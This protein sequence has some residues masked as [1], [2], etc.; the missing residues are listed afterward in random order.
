MNFDSYT[1]TA[2][3]G[4]IVT[5]L[6]QIAGIVVNAILVKRKAGLGAILSLIGFS[7]LLLVD[8]CGYAYNVFLFQVIFS[9]VGYDAYDIING[10]YQCIYS[11]TT[12]IS[13]GLLIFG[14]WKLGQKATGE[15]DQEE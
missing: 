7:V 12:A 8:I 3:L 4:I 9:T 1:I 11:L 5:T 10:S 13:F 2:T 6:A 14:I 15:A